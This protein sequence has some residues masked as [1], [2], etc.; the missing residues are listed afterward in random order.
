MKIPTKIPHFEIRPATESD[1]PFILSFVK[2]LAKYEGL[3]HEVVATEAILRESLFGDRRVA[4]VLIGDYK[5][6]PVSFS[7]FF[8][9]FSTFLGRP[10]TYIEDLYVLPEF[11]GRGFGRA[12][13]GYVAQL[14]KARNCGRLEWSVLDWNKPAIELYKRLGAVPMD[15]WTVYRVT[16]DALAR[17][18]NES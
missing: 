1:V 4:E 11:R 17:L 10:G 9:S 6:R 15:K 3:S 2:Q 18:T 12:L 16:G 5:G 7:L 14:A 8:P 13:L